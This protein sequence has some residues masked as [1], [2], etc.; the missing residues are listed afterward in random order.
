MLIDW[1]IIDGDWSSILLLGN[2]HRGLVGSD[3][4]EV[5]KTLLVEMDLLLPAVEEHTGE[6]DSD[7]HEDDE[8]EDK[9]HSCE[10]VD[11]VLTLFEGVV[12]L[13]VEF[14]IVVASFI[15]V[16]GDPVIIEHK[17]ENDDENVAEGA[18]D[19]ADEV[20]I[21]EVLAVVDVVL[22]VED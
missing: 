1:R 9:S 18:Y 2:D 21:V 13:W 12:H 8:S 6:H 7:G 20:D 17:E 5:I 22:L 10:C 4:S 11:E 14:R 19:G 15:E 3:L 16:W